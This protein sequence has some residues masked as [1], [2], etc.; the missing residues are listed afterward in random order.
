[1]GE[2]TNKDL[3]RNTLIDVVYQNLLKCRFN[4]L[5]KIEKNKY[6]LQITNII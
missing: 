1:M 5:N 4:I 2:R 6:T 3:E